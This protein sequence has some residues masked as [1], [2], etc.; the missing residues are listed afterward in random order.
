MYEAKTIVFYD[1]R[2]I[3][4]N[5]EMGFFDNIRLELTVHRK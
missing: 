5:H 4:D 2:G 3:S 1:P